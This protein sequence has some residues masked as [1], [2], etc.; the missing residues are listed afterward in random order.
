MIKNKRL[1]LIIIKILRI[2][3]LNNLFEIYLKHTC[4]ITL[5]YQYKKV[6]LPDNK[7]N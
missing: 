3:K 5:F 4:L 6:H 7:I 2:N 1:A